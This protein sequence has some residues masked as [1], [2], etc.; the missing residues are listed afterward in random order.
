MSAIGTSP[1]E[2]RTVKVWDPFVRVAH[3]VLAAVFLVAYAI[4]DDILTLHVWFG[5]L[6]GAIVVARLAWGLV[7][8]RHARFSD[9]ICPPRIVFAYLAD[10]LLFRARRYLG[11]SPA[12]GAMAIALWLGVLATVGSG[13]AAYGAEG[14][15]PLAGYFAAAGSSAAVA[16][17]W[18]DDGDGGKKRK[19]LAAKFWEETHEIL[20]G[21][22]LSLVVVHVAG[23]AWASIAHRENLTRAMWDGKKR[24]DGEEPNSV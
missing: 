14:K 12:G 22:S 21:I 13:L 10:L 17:T 4:E 18:A 1:S 23:V 11:H 8:P 7:G 20:A 2:I 19:S 6:A 16:Q 15:G 5:Y 3:W 9:F 24:P